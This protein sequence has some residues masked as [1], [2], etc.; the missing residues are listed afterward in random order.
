MKLDAGAAYI[1][2]VSVIYSC[3]DCIFYKLYYKLLL[4]RFFIDEDDLLVVP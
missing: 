2:V 1:F 3:A 4:V